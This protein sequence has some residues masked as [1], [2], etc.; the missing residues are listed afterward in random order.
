ML[1]QTMARTIRI[2][3]LTLFVLLLAGCGAQG[4]APV[5]DA[6]P[7][8]TPPPTAPVILPTETPLPPATVTPYPTATPVEDAEPA[9]PADETAPE[10]GAASEGDAPVEQP[11]QQS[12]ETQPTPTTVPPPTQ[13]PAQQA[14][15]EVPAGITIGSV[16][17]QTDY[18]A[19]WP[20]YDDPTARLS[21]TSAAYLFEVGPFDAR[22]ITTS[23]INDENYYVSIEATPQECPAGGG[24]G[25]IFR[26]EDAANYHVFT[27]YCDNT[28]AV[29]S[30]IGGSLVGVGLERQ[31]L[32][33][34]LDVT[35]PETHVISVLAV[36]DKFVLYFDGETV[37]DFIDNAFPAGDVGPYAATNADAWTRVSFDNLKV[38][39]A[40]SE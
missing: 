11:E 34:G 22:F 8:S 29:A 35:T 4:A 31:A 1:V 9:V 28:F 37:A 36:G 21:I 32:P 27:L 20:S 16:Y 14:D 39:S 6:L 19:G 25:L 26:Y 2:A 24:Y 40:R 5:A 30:R 7:T 38:Q 18:S 15:V 10:D 13:P 17:Y 12:D 33:A 3:A 23:A